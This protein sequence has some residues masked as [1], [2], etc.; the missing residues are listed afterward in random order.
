MYNQFNQS[1]SPSPPKEK[2]N[3]DENI[4]TTNALNQTT[5]D[6]KPLK[7][8]YNDK[9]TN[10]SPKIRQY[11]YQLHNVNNNNNNNDNTVNNIKYVNRY[12]NKQNP[13]LIRNI[14]EIN[15]ADG[16]FYSKD[17]RETS[18]SNFSQSKCIM[19]SNLNDCS[20]ND[21]R[22]VYPKETES[23]EEIHFAFVALLIESKKII[24]R[25]ENDKDS[26]NNIFCFNTVLRCEE[27]D[28]NE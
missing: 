16:R 13:L 26:N 12:Q 1:F 6:Q 24:L 9:L 10:L 19:E 18:E 7:R 3:K 25:Q 27:R 23:I 11:N 14:K 17:S 21:S 5:K 4:I 22:R 15:N 2:G 28:I 20:F 8:K